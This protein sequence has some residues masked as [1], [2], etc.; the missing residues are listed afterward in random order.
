M[1]GGCRFRSVR[2]LQK[3]FCGP[4]LQRWIVLINQGMSVGSTGPAYFRNLKRFIKNVR[5]YA[6]ARNKLIADYERMKDKD[7]NKG[8][9]Q[10]VLLED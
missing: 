9:W 7:L 3:P 4:L 10:K 1:D 5:A 6:K 2:C 8:F